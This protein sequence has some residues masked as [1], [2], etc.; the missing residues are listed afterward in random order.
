MNEPQLNPVHE[1]NVE[2]SHLN[3]GPPKQDT[4]VTP[5]RTTVEGTGAVVVTRSVG[6]QLQDRATR[7]EA[8][9]E[10]GKDAKG[11]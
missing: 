3:Y 11:S 7:M 2:P 10:Q 4:P 5:L 1:W 9:N 6:G 8:M